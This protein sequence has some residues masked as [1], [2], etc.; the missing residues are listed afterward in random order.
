MVLQKNFLTS[1][2]IVI[3]SEMSF[4]VVN[5]TERQIVLPFVGSVPFIISTLPEKSF[6]GIETQSFISLLG[7]DKIIEVVV[8]KKIIEKTTTYATI[9]INRCNYII[10]AIGQQAKLKEDYYASFGIA[11]FVDSFDISC[12]DTKHLNP[13][14]DTQILLVNYRSQI[15]ELIREFA[16]ENMRVNLRQILSNLPKNRLVADDR[17]MEISL[18]MGKQELPIIQKINSKF[19]IYQSIDKYFDII[20]SSIPINRTDKVEITVST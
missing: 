3:D 11:D 8:S 16:I 19:M 1:S 5:G 6:G 12:V 14:N 7:L 20:I 4:V 15:G 17:L 2:S 18:L 10:F 9:N 13:Q